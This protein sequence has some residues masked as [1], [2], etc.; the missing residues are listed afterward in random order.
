LYVQGESTT[1][2]LT[3]AQYEK[4]E[5]TASEGKLISNWIPGTSSTVA[6][7]LGYPNFENPSTNP[8]VPAAPGGVDGSYEK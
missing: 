8:V 1:L 5:V 2:T 3:F 7:I 4:I 6:P